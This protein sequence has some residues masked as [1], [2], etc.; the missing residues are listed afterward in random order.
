MYKIYFATI[1]PKMVNKCTI[2]LNGMC[3]IYIT[4]N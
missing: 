1:Q 2:Y 4:V 3:I